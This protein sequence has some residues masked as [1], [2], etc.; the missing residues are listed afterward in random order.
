[1]K[2]NDVIIPKALQLVLDDFGWFYGRDVRD[3]GGPA[4]AGFP[5]EFEI[6]DYEMMNELGKAMNEEVMGMFVGG[7]WDREGL[8]ASVPNSSWAGKNWK[9]SRWYNEEKAKQIVELYNSSENLEW[10]VHGLL[11]DVWDEN[12]ALLGGGEYFPFEGDVPTGKRL[13]P[14]EEYLRSHLDAYFKIYDTIGFKDRPR[15]FTAPSGGK[16]AFISDIFAKSLKRYGITYWHN[17]FEVTPHGGQVNLGD[18]YIKDGTSIIRAAYVL[19]LWETYDLDPDSLPDITYET[20]G[21][22][23]GHWPNILR[24]P[25]KKSKDNLAAWVNFFNRHAEVFGLMISRDIAFAHKQYHYAMH[26]DIRE[27][28]GAVV[29]DL[30]EPDKLNP[31]DEIAPI[32]ISI[33]KGA[34]EPQI[35]GGEARVYEEKKDFITYEIKRTDSNQIII[36]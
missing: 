1:M 14:S 18:H 8:L 9:G 17:T 15:A 25:A 31:F 21:L 36:K 35:S 12:G 4:R 6:E 2:K 28:N 24:F 11:H 5:R 19:C 10:G 29:I 34:G 13:N 22:V 16:T 27:E 23:A 32:Y 33:K 20:G 7:E 26:S 3:Q 30:A